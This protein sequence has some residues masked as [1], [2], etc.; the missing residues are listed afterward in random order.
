LLQGELD[1]E[2]GPAQNGAACGAEAGDAIAKRE[3]ARLQAAK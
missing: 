2:H 3:L 1:A